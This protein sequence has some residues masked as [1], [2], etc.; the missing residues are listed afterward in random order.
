MV[1]ED[2]VEKEDNPAESVKESLRG[3]LECTVSSTMLL[4]CFLVATKRIFFPDLSE[5]IGVGAEY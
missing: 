5:K 4:A 2:E 1:D 3:R